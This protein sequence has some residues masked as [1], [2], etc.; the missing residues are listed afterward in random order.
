ML[1]S[2]APVSDCLR[3]LGSRSSSRSSSRFS[4]F[5]AG[6]FGRYRN[7]I[8]LSERIG[9]WAAILVG[10]VIALYVS[11]V[12]ATFRALVE[13]AKLRAD[14]QTDISAQS[15]LLFERAIAEGHQ[16]FFLHVPFHE[17][18]ATLLFALAM[19]AFVYAA[20]TGY[21]S[22]DAVPGY[23]KASEQSNQDEEACQAAENK[24]RADLSK[25]ATDMKQKRARL[26]T[27]INEAARLQRDLVIKSDSCAKRLAQ[28]AESTNN[29]YVHAVSSCRAENTKHR[30]T[31][32]PEYFSKSIRPCRSIPPP[33]ASKSSRRPRNDER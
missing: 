33:R 17:L 15:P 22:S 27:A 23:S 14:A 1:F 19:I 29:D 25:L 6:Y 9:G 2:T 28:F 5:L 4:D 13:I 32:P 11:S 30:A 16:I 31:Q 18:N 12:T 26:V 24:L 7:S 20:Y 8:R 3:A 10:L 21:T